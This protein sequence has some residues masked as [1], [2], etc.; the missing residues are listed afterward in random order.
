MDA[1]EME[2]ESISIQHT[3]GKTSS[4]IGA[5]KHGRMASNYSSAGDTRNYQ[6]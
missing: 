1:E 3:L 4:P 6:Y 2:S 5:S